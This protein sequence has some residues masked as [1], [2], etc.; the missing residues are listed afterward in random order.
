MFGDLR[1]HRERLADFSRLV[2]EVI[3]AQRMRGLSILVADAIGQHDPRWRNFFTV[4]RDAF[5]HVIAGSPFKLDVDCDNIRME[6]GDLAECYRRCVRIANDASARCFDKFGQNPDDDRRVL[7]HIDGYV[8]R[9]MVEVRGVVVDIVH[10]VHY[11]RIA[12]P[13]M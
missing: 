11:G 3:S 6:D 7:N 12:A 1:Q 8:C 9:F 2:E 13:A 4:D 5:Q 10:A